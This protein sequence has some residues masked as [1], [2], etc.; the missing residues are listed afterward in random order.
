[1]STSDRTGRDGSRRALT[2]TARR[3]L[4]EELAVLC[5][6][7]RELGGGFGLDPAG[8]SVDSATALVRA[9][10]LARVE[11]RIAEVTDLLARGVEMDE[12][13]GVPG[14]LEPGS[15]V[16][17]RFPDGSV[18]TLRVV[19]IVEETAEG[20][21]ATTLTVG[22]PLGRAL[23]GC[24]AGDRI[25]YATPAGEAHAQ[26]VAIRPPDNPGHRSRTTAAAG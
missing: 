9:D 13:A 17:L 23:A 22:S 20:E 21:E 1:M 16:T 11:G 25:A 4:E 10:D 19:A 12:V 2:S 7:R 14:H 26:V 8:D 15:E 3:R 18:D 6:Q 24:R 5:G